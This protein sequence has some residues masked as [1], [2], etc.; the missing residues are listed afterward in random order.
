[1]NKKSF[2]GLP[3]NLVSLWDE[4]V[5]VVFHARN[6]DAA[7]V[8]QAL[9]EPTTVMEELSR[10]AARFLQH[11]GSEQGRI[12]VSERDGR[13]VALRLERIEHARISVVHVGLYGLPSNSRIEVYESDVDRIS[14]WRISRPDHNETLVASMVALWTS[15]QDP[16]NELRPGH[17]VAVERLSDGDYVLLQFSG[18]Q[19]EIPFL[20]YVEGAD[21]AERLIAE[22][23][24][25]A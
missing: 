21:E 23:K 2:A 14:A 19:S 8:V 15:V 17:A 18:L 1:M 3:A 9:G 12:A 5:I 25:A 22:S 24:E 13:A 16:A 20:L 7:S 10:L 11:A 4:D 6:V